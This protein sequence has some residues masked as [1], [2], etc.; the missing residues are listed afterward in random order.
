MLIQLL[1]ATTELSATRA[2]AYYLLFV[3]S[4]LAVQQLADADPPRLQSLAQVPRVVAAGATYVVGGKA[5][6]SLPAGFP[7]NVMAN[8]LLPLLALY[9][10]GRGAAMSYCE[11]P[12][13]R[14]VRWAVEPTSPSGKGDLF[15]VSLSLREGKWAHCQPIIVGLSTSRYSH[16]GRQKCYS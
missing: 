2:G 13:T 6:A 7:L 4:I 16:T 12:L 5:P 3:R 10:P 8:P 11:E 1:V 15:R 14:L 9:A